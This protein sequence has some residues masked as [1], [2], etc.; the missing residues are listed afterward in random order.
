MPDPGSL[1][2]APNLATFATLVFL[3]LVLAGDNLVL[4]AILT[5]KLPE[6]YRPMARRFGLIA[7]VATRILLLFSLFWLSHID[8][9]IAGTPFTPRV[10]VFGLGGLFLVWKAVTELL[11]LF[12]GDVESTIPRA[13]ASLSA[14]TL[15][16][17]QIAL[18]DIVFSL[19]SVIAAIGLAKQIEI[20]VAAVVT[21]AL[22]MLFLVN[23]ISNII[24]RFRL[25]KAAALNLLVIIGVLLLAHVEPAMEHWLPSTPALILGFIAVLI[26][27]AMMLAMSRPL[28]LAMLGVVAA[29][30]LVVALDRNLQAQVGGAWGQGVAQLEAVLR[31]ILPAG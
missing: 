8:T 21:A 14:I 6:R 20:M 5:G 30:A 9:K 4:I 25:V 19:D 1:L 23:P 28:R 16:I 15:V 13:R 3:E 26:V 18:F 27:Q 11:V 24:E 22:F 12:F 17:A 10:I 29:S 2:S 31:P 7:A